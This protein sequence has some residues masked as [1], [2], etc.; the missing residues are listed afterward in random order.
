MLWVTAD[1]TFRFIDPAEVAAVERTDRAIGFDARRGTRPR[2]PSRAH[3][4]S[5]VP[6]L[7]LA[8]RTRLS[9][10]ER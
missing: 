10:G 7:R 2:P 4:R 1:A 8:C 6:T 9:S 3:Q 5:C